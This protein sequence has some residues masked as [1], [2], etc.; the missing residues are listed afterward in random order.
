MQYFIIISLLSL[1]LYSSEI[2][3]IEAIVEDIENLRS[4]YVLCQTALNQV[5]LKSSDNKKLQLLQRENQEYSDKL[6][7]EKNTNKILSSKIDLLE[8]DKNKEKL[9]K[10]IKELKSL[11]LAKENR[12]NNLDKTIKDL[13]KNRQKMNNSLS[14]LQK[15]SQKKAIVCEDDNVFPPLVM[16]D[17]INISKSEKVKVVLA[18]SF[19]LNKESYIYN[20]IDGE[21]VQQWENRRT[22]TSNIMS[23]N[24][25]KITGY[26]VDKVWQK[27]IKELWIKKENISKR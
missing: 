19:R 17:G 10:D 23:E 4:E 20:A 16:K 27:A 13:D 14:L 6:N 25:I 18:G 7:K 24:W 1:S 12:I 8:K 15:S 22:F 3:R 9:L 21:I 2:D 26:F 5:P 11:L